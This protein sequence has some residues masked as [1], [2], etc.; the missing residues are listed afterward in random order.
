MIAGILD[1]MRSDYAPAVRLVWQCLENHAN[2]ERCWRMTH[3]QIADELR[4]SCDTV[5]RAVAELEADGILRVE[6]FRRRVSTFHMLRTYPSAGADGAGPAYRNGQAAD[7]WTPQKHVPISNDHVE[8]TTGKPESTS[9]D[10][11][12]TPQK[13][14]P[15]GNSYVGLTPQIPDSTAN[16]TPQIPDSTPELTPQKPDPLSTSKNPPGSPP[17]RG[18]R[19]S[20]RRTPV[21]PHWYPDAAGERYARERSVPI[22]PTVEKFR[23]HHVAH[24]KVMAD[25]DAAWRTWVANE[26]VFGQRSRGAPKFRNGFLQVIADEGM[27]SCHPGGEA[28]PVT[29]FLELSRHDLH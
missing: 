10:H 9:N 19:A 27:P 16:L 1:A 28:N 22:A 5:A 13:P 12:L 4:L 15:T 20:R 8:L 18:A 3:D 24:G 26:V 17:V 21:P 11:A 6:R 7:D 14:D 25:W 2:T 29:A 23:D